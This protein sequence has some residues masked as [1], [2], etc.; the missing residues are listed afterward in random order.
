MSNYPVFGADNNAVIGMIVAVETGDGS[1][2]AYGEPLRR[3]QMAWPPMARPYKGLARFEPADADFFFGREDIVSTL[4]GRLDRDPVT[5]IVGASG[6]GKSSLV[7][8]GLLPKLDSG[9]WQVAA[10]RPGREPVSNLAWALAELMAPRADPSGLLD[11]VD[12]I[13]RKLNQTPDALFETARALHGAFL[14]RLLL[15]VDQFEELFT[16]CRDE[17]EQAT[18]VNLVAQAG[19]LQTPALV[20]VIATLRADFL[21][22][23]LRVPALGELFDGRY[24]MLRAMNG[25]ELGRA[26]RNPARVLGVEFEMGVDDLMLAAVAKDASALPLMEFAL[27]RLWVEQENR[28]L[29]R[30]AYDRMGGLEGALARHAD[31]V[32]DRM[33]EPEQANVRRLLCQLVNVARPGEGEDTKRPQSRQELGEELW[34]VAQ[35]LSDQTSGDSPQISARLVVL[36]RDEQQ[37]E[38]ADIIHEALIRQWPRL[39]SWLNEERPYLLTVDE[40]QRA[41]KRWE[42]GRL[43]ERL[44]RGL[45]IEQAIANRERLLADHPGL[46]SL[47]EKSR[48]RA[49]EESARLKADTIWEPLEFQFA[50]ISQR[51]LESLRELAK[52]DDRVRRA[53]LQRLCEIPDRARRFCRLPRP[54]LRAALGLRVRPESL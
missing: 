34:S 25:E 38:V 9:T 22:E 6:G 36:Y 18:F 42:D 30:S 46:H 32:V 52:A 2:I 5:L 29:V 13:R 43:P 10:F 50:R 21:A 3:L 54:V 23:V 33:S 14:T 39:S 53:F 27:E 31:E 51:E 20:N 11:R 8:G 7:F 19:R 4:L 35:R 17:N 26:I 16:L 15:I 48:E 41:R 12:D 24:F 47:I 45:D 40:L 1:R 49:L 44:L 37:R 28:R